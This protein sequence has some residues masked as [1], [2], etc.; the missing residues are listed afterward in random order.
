MIVIDGQLLDVFKSVNLPSFEM[1]I[2]E[3]NKRN[4]MRIFVI[5]RIDENARN[6]VANTRAPIIL[7]IQTGFGKQIILDDKN[8]SEEYLMGNPL[9]NN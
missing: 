9:E 6:F 2:L 4:D 3:I 5:L 1:Q 8:L 7:N